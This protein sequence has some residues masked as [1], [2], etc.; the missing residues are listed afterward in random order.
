MLLVNIFKVTKY[1][2]G[3][4]F[5]LNGNPLDELMYKIK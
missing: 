2:L 1:F 5:Q 3:H 4:G